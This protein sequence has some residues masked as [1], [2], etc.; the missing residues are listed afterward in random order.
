MPVRLIVTLKDGTEVETSADVPTGAPGGPPFGP[1]D[2][3]AKFRRL[4]P[5]LGARRAGELEDVVMNLELHSAAELAA[6][7][8]PPGDRPWRP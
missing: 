7:A 8:V 1:D 2:V 3:R 4:A 5:V 6:L